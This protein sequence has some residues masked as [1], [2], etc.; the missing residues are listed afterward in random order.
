M[1]VIG[2]PASVQQLVLQLVAGIL[3]LGNISFCEEGNYARVESA[4]RECGRCRE[5]GVRLMHLACFVPLLTPR[6]PCWCHW[7][8]SYVLRA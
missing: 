7:G 5:L 2:I 3:H 4:D 1:Q 6:E 8:S